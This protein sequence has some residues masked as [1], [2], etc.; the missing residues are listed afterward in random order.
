MVKKQESA[1]GYRPSERTRKLFDKYCGETAKMS[2]GQLIDIALELILV[3]PEAK[4]DDLIWAILR[5]RTEE[6]KKII[7]LK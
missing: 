5:G 6:A 1:I 7:G 3:F 2:R 4:Q